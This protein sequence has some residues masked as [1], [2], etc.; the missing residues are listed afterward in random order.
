MIFVASLVIV[1]IIVLLLWLALQ[2][3]YDKIGSFASK[4]LNPFNIKKETDKNE[5]E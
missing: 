1:I 3:L 2:P 5:N 4:F